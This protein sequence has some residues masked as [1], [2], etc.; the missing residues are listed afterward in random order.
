L[1]NDS[2]LLFQYQASCNYG[3]HSINLSDDIIKKIDEI[4][5]WYRAKAFLDKI[6]ATEIPVPVNLDL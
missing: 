5:V 6:V 3:R 1:I 2:Q 4:I